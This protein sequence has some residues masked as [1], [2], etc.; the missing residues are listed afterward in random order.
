MEYGDVHPFVLQLVA[1]D[2]VGICLSL[3]DHWSTKARAY[4]T[5]SFNK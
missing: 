3:H 5:L 4:N 1:V 2:V